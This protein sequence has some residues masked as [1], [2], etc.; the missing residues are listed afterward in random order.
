VAFEGKTARRKTPC[1]SGVLSCQNDFAG[2]RGGDLDGKHLPRLNL[3]NLHGL[4]DCFQLG[5]IWRASGVRLNLQ[6]Q[7]NLRHFVEANTGFCDADYRGLSRK[8]VLHDLLI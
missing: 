3:R 2:I 6:G 8:A 1:G 5:L 7:L 4:Y